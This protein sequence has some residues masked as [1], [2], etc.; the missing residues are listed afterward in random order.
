MTIREAD[1]KDGK[2]DWRGPR[3]G[4]KARDHAATK[5]WTMTLP[6]GGSMVPGRISR[7]AAAFLRLLPR[8]V[9]QDDRLA[10]AAAIAIHQGSC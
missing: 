9:A 3:S 4:A 2:H 10:S 1:G 7:L 8:K 6:G 5:A